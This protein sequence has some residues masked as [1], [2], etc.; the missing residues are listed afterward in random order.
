MG[1]ATAS[2][3]LETDPELVSGR[4]CKAAQGPRRRLTPATLQASNHRL[5]GVHS[6]GDFGLGEPSIQAR[7]DDRRHQRKLVIECIIGRPIGGIS[8]RLREYLVS[9]Y[10][11]RLS[12]RSARIPVHVTSLA[13]ASAMSISRR[14]VFCVFFVNTR[15]MMMRFPLRV[16]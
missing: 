6:L 14:G 8:P 15:T 1:W 2:V 5:C 3:G 16:T 4:L 12:R 7:L 10:Q 9:G 13:R 11:P